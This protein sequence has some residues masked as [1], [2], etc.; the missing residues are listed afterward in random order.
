M[1]YQVKYFPFIVIKLTQCRSNNFNNE[2]YKFSYFFYFLFGISNHLIVYILN[3]KWN[4]CFVK[5]NLFK[6]FQSTSNKVI[7]FTYFLN[8][9]VLKLLIKETHYVDFYNGVQ[10]A[11]A[12]TLIP[13]ANSVSRHGNCCC[14]LERALLNTRDIRDIQLYVPY[15]GRSNNG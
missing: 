4:I 7:K 13:G 8:L 10:G 15:K 9:P 11:S 5:Y 2:V 6:S 1:L 12:A 3:I 14:D